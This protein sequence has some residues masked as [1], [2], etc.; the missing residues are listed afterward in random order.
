MF[1]VLLGSPNDCVTNQRHPVYRE[2]HVM[3]GLTVGR[4]AKARAILPWNWSIVRP[5]C[6]LHMLRHRCLR[7]LYAIDLVLCEKLDLC[8]NLDL[9]DSRVRN[10]A[11]WQNITVW[12]TLGY[13]AAIGAPALR[14]AGPR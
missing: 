5:A 8:G 4:K 10:H 1:R 13:I 6:Q 11:A 3:L 12:S 14:V 9:L 2:G 7:A